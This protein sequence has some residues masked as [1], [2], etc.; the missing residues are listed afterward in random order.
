M[1]GSCLIDSSDTQSAQ[2]AMVLADP[3][4]RPAAPLLPPYRLSARDT[5]AALVGHRKL[6]APSL[7]QYIQLGHCIPAASPL[8]CLSQSLQLRLSQSNEIS[9][10]PPGA[11]LCNG[12]NGMLHV[13]SQTVKRGRQPFRRPSC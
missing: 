5:P 4:Y 9:A 11:E 12:I 7:I 2:P 6:G 10:R 8:Q 13:A 1:S 3:S